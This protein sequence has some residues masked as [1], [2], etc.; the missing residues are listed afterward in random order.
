MCG[1]APGSVETYVQAVDYLDTC[2][3]CSFFSPYL[4]FSVQFLAQVL[5]RSYSSMTRDFDIF[6]CNTLLS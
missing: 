6:L 1:W 2:S 4:F 5:P 3:L